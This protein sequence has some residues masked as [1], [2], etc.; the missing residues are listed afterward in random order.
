MVIS[1]FV[2]D[3]FDENQKLKY[4]QKPPRGGMHT[5]AMFGSVTK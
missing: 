4:G 1:I 2:F 5:T 3:M